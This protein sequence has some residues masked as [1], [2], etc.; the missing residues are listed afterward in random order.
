MLRPPTATAP[1]DD[2]TICRAAI[3]LPRQCKSLSLLALAGG[4]VLLAPHLTGCARTAVI[5]DNP[6]PD[7]T[8]L[9]TVEHIPQ[10][11]PTDK[12]LIVRE[13]Q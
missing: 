2:A 6:P 7:T 3:A 4:C 1:A 9:V 13:K 8:T 12:N 5:V 11:Q 10:T